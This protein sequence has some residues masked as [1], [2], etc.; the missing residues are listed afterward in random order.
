[1]EEKLLNQNY[2]AP[3][4]EIIDIELNQNLLNGGSEVLAKKGNKDEM[5]RKK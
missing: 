5:K 3:D 2:V 1:M 4:I